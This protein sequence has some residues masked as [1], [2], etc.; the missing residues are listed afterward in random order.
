MIRLH[1]VHRCP[2]VPNAL[3][4]SASVAS[5]RSA[6]GMTIAAFFPPISREMRFPSLPHCSASR[7]PVSV[8]PVKET[9]RT[10]GWETSASPTPW[11]GPVTMLSTP[12]GS[13]A[14]SKIWTN[15]SATS[16]V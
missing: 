11:P 1:A 14:S 9:T 4:M 7:S 5:P 12:G 13:P 8:E 6:S 16:G 3:Q 2:D 10:W 15:L